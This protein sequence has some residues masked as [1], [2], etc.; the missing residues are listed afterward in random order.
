MPDKI[1]ILAKSSLLTFFIFK[2]F[3]FHPGDC[4][5][6]RKSPTPM[7]IVA[8]LKLRYLHWTNPDM[9]GQKWTKLDRI[10]AQVDLI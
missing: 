7:A 1:N 2:Y 6:S 10:K 4:R 9:I 5:S 8:I 3:E